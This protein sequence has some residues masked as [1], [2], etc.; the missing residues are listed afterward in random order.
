MIEHTSHCTV[1]WIH[2]GILKASL[3]CFHLPLN[4]VKSLRQIGFFLSSNYIKGWENSH[5]IWKLF[6]FL[7][8]ISSYHHFSHIHATRGEPW[9]TV[10]SH[11]IYIY[12]HNW[13][14]DAA[15]GGARRAN[16]STAVQYVTLTGA[17][18]SATCGFPIGV[19]IGV[20]GFGASADWTTD[21][22]G[23]RNRQ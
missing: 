21:E 15:T 4:F 3:Q 2:I 19:Q 22:C 11:A 8:K 12:P 7:S 16:N 1:R 10:P 14:E 6:L 17:P 5:I 13:T 20:N 23:L 9:L 18:G